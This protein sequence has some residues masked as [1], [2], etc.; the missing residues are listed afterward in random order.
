MYKKFEKIIEK[1]FGHRHRYRYGNISKA[2]QLCY[3]GCTDI[4]SPE[5]R[6]CE[7]C[8]K[9]LE[10]FFSA[11][12]YTYDTHEEW[13]QTLENAVQEKLIVILPDSE[14]IWN[15]PPNERF[16]HIRTTSDGTLIK[17]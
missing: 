4:I 12:S 1:L 16:P 13:W 17:C 8:D 2:H 10:I 14:L 15:N 9:Q 6:K 3:K 5:V 7:T 11:G